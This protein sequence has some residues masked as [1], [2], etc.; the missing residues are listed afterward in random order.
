[1]IWCLWASV[2][3]VLGAGAI[4]LALP[5]S[6]APHTKPIVIGDGGD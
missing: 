6:A 5:R 2:A 4:S 3:F 1:L